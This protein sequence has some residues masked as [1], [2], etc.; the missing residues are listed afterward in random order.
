MDVHNYQRKCF[1]QYKES[2][3]FPQERTFFFG[4]PVEVAVPHEVATDKVMVIGFHPLAKVFDLEDQ[5]DVPLYSANFPFGNEQ[6]FDGKHVVDVPGRKDLEVVLNRLGIQLEDCWL[7]SL[8]K[9]YLFSS[10]DVI[11]YNKLGSYKVAPDEFN[12]KEYG[13]KSMS[14]IQQE[15]NLAN[16]ELVILVGLET[17]SLF[18]DLSPTKAKHLVDGELKDLKI[19]RKKVPVLCLQDPELMINNNKRNPWPEVFEN[20][21]LPAASESLKAFPFINK[22]A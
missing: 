7:T 4:N 15:V 5:K 21:V 2:I 20:K 18:Y 13:A 12:F 19:G 1:K 3:G 6:Y 11:K 9:I 14:W 10:K 8:I 22:P 16:P 17:I